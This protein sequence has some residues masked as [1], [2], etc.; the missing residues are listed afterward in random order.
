M[1]AALPSSV[2]VGSETGEGVVFLSA[3]HWIEAVLLGPVATS[4]AVIAVASIGLLMLSGRVRMRRG[5]T[6]IVGCFI[7]FGAASIAHGLRGTAASLAA[8]PPPQP[9]PPQSAP[10]PA[11][12][13][14]PP[15][16]APPADPYAGASIRR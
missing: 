4:I 10:P 12:L 7:L 8:A 9:M 6:V 14:P 2:R 13:P 15:A 11:P 16:P 5:A 3:A 1:T